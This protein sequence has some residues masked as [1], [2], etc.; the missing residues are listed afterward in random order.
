MIEMAKKPQSIASTLLR[1]LDPLANAF[2]SGKSRAGPEDKRM[3]TKSSSQGAKS[4]KGKVNK[5]SPK[6]GSAKA[7]AADSKSASPSRSSSKPKRRA[8]KGNLS[9]L[10]PESFPQMAQIAGVMMGTARTEIKYKNRDDILVMQL[11]SGTQAAGVLTKSKMPSVP[12]DWCRSLLKDDQGIDGARMLVVNAGNANVFTG[13]VGRD[14]VKATVTEASKLAAC[15]QKDVV[16]AS[17]GVIGEKLTVTPLLKGL[18]RAHKDLRPTG[19]KK[20]ARSIMTTD[21]FPKGSYATAEIDGKPIN[22][23][24]IAKG[25]GMIAPDMATMLAFIFTDAAIPS[26]ILQTLLSINVRHTF[27]SI[28]VDGDTS[29]S[30]AVFLFATGAGAE[31]RPITRVGDRRLIEFRKKL[32]TV[33]TDLAQQ[34]VRDG[35]GATK[36][37]VVNVKGAASPKSAK[38]I[39]M[40]IGNSPLVKTAI[41]GEDANWGRIVMAIG[42][43]GEPAD[44]DKLKI[45]I[46]GHRVVRNGAADPSYRE[47]VALRH[48]QG[49]QI[50]IT[51]DIG[52]GQ[53]EATIWTC[54]LTDKYIS[55][56]ADYRS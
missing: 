2:R 40:A 13:Q 3:P 43:A 56:N 29:T 18:R 6:K 30:D 22:I 49:D 45:W 36:F 26:P 19:W 11:E 4:K 23:C 42:K 31:H 14:A 50:D 54:D 21:T 38:A 15:R 37:I 55:I 33:M 34:I 8:A 20:A 51:V 47:A 27:N 48:L 25:A 35:E 46:G 32:S 28:T 5:S 24:G 53:G 52:L 1:Q 9:P 16:V 7:N 10:A 44:R 17:T 39:A 12:I 41:A